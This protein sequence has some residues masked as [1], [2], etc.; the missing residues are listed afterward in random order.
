MNSQIY[1]FK[2]GD[3]ARLDI[4]YVASQ[5]I[6]K[7]KYSLP[8]SFGQPQE[9]VVDLVVKLNNQN[10]TYSGIPANA[11]IADCFSNGENVVIS[12]NRDAISSEVLN[13][14]QKSLDIISSVPYNEKQV[15]ACDRILSELHPEFADKKAQ[16]EELDS[17]KSQVN[18]MAQSINNLMETNRVLIEKLSNKEI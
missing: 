14:K 3:N 9:L 16:K 2:K 4:G 7:P 18:E 12:D 10:V 13:V 11:D 1:I 5:P 15:E 8:T 17:L 6:P